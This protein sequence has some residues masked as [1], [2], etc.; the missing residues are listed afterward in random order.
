MAE[1]IWRTLLVISFG[2][3]VGIIVFGVWEF[4]VVIENLNSAGNSVSKPPPVLNRASLESTLSA[5]RD[6]EAAFN[7]LDASPKTF[8]DPSK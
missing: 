1:I 8:A 4:W 2:A 3:V 7:A 5:I 6:R